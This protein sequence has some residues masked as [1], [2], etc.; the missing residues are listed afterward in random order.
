MDAADTIMNPET[1][2][3]A[4]PGLAHA[5]ILAG[6]LEQKA[7]EE[8]FQKAQSNRTSFIAELTGS[9][10]VSAF[11][12][13]HTLSTAF[14]APLVDLDAIDP[15]ALPKG[16]LDNKI[17]HDFRVVVLSKRDNRLI[18]AT[19][20]PS[21]PPGAGKDQVCYPVARRLGRCRIRQTAQVRDRQRSDSVRDDRA[22][23]RR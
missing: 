23:H 15:K 9:G 18:V 19:A 20:D 2:T 17:S 4:L 14:A 7:A 8:I 6:K 13:A 16:L 1:E 5:L 12:L 22:H 10:V 11:D 21:E 3:T